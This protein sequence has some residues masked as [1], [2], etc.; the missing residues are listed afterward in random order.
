MQ[1]T[2]HLPCSFS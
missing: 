2:V 1:H